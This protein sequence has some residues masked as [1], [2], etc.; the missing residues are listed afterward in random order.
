M[1]KILVFGKG[2]LERTQHGIFPFT[3]PYM[4]NVAEELSGEIPSLALVF[5]PSLV[6][7][8]HGASQ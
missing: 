3:Y 4:F 8:E 5:R 2:I 7:T 1:T 6:S